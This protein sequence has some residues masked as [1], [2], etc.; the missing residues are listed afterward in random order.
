MKNLVKMSQDI[1]SDALNQIMNAKKAKKSELKINRFS[2][3]L[4]KILDIMKSNDYIDYEIKG[5]ELII[6]IKKI[7]KCGSI[8]PRFNVSTEEIEKYVK[9]FLPARDFGI[10]IVSTNKG[11]L[12]HYDAIEQNVGGSLLAYIF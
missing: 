9:R 12:S 4:L 6:S 10:L 11:L 5:K 8:K 1:V 3:V 2:K 7:N